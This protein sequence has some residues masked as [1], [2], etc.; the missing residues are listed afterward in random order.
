M[1]RVI[2]IDPGSLSFDLCGLDDGHVFLDISLAA[3]DAARTPTLLVDHLSAAGPLDLIAAPSGYGLPLVPVGELSLDQLNLFILVRE[4]DRGQ[5]EMVGG[6]RAMVEMMRARHLPAIV[7]PGV[8][9]LPTVPAHR[10]VNRIDMGTADKVCV[11]ALGISDQARRLDLPPRETSFILVELGGT[12]TAAV[13]VEQGQIVDGIGGTAGGLGYRA[14]GTLDGE[15][16]YALGRIPKSLLFSGGAA[17][18][19]GEPDLA[20]ESL[21]ERAP[22]DGRAR[23]ACDAFLESVE[24]MVAALGVSLPEPREILLSG[25][26]ALVP[27]IADA[28]AARLKATAPVRAVT[29]FAARSKEAAQ[30]AALIADGLA[31]GDNRALVETMRLREAGGTVLDHLCVPGVEVIRRQ[32]RL[33]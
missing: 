4:D 17:F 15:V 14:L 5:P 21:W 28:A 22:A 31:G 30:G 19:A 9:H 29:R 23:R 33:P 26:L 32:F 3:P 2:G 11:A 13:A 12:F 10:K 1:P 18:V 8:V 25:R 24:K 27:A 20:P 7:L 16:A 6:L